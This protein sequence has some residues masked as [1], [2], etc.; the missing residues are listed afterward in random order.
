MA[1]YDCNL[2][3]SDAALSDLTS[4]LIAVRMQSMSILFSLR[5]NEKAKLPPENGGGSK[6]GTEPP[7]GT[8]LGGRSALVNG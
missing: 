3:T 1:E 4:L 8:A 5:F 6:V 2:S 7:A